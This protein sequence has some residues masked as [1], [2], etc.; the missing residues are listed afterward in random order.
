MGEGE[1]CDHSHEHGNHPE[2]PSGSKN[3]GDS[4]NSE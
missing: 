2:Q 3:N 1:K 4:E